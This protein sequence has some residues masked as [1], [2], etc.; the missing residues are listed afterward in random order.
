MI[1]SKFAG[2]LFLIVVTGMGA[3]LHAKVT[4][5]QRYA[6]MAPL[7][8]YLIA[9]PKTEIA[10]ARSAAPPAIANHAEVMVLTR[11]G[12]Q[13]AVPGQN[14]FLCLVERSWAKSTGSWDFWNPKMRS[15]NCFN[16]QA[17]ASFA[18]IYLL[19]T[20]WV[21]AGKTKPEIARALA[22][23]FRQGRL[24]RLKPGAMCYMMSQ[25]QY[26]NDQARQWYPH[27]MFFEPL[28]MAHSWG[29]NLPGS[30]VIAARDPE[31][32]ATIFMVKV[33]HWSNGHPGPAIH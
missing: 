17:A 26:L 10:L 27:L 25:Q 30:P 16:A 11:T 2:I 23:A 20:K 14:G 4:N 7:R 13:V 5:S 19:K 1:Q 31:E 3:S 8:Q 28:N 22:A 33:S 15:P 6:S 18:P 32:K 9:N 29:A 21:L 24:P 12:Y